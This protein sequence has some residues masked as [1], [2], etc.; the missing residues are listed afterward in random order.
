[1]GSTTGEPVGGCPDGWTRARTVTITNEPDKPLSNFQTLIKVAWDNDMQVDFS[2]LRFVDGLGAPLPH[3]IEDYTAPIEATVWVKVPAIAA[4]GTTEI[5]M[6]YG[7]PDAASGSDGLSTFI[8]FDDFDGA[9]LDAKKWESTLPVTVGA[10]TLK[11]ANGAVYSKGSPGAFPNLMIET[12]YKHAFG[13]PFL[14]ISGA[15]IPTVPRIMV[16]VGYLVYAFVNNDPIKL[17]EGTFPA[18]CCSSPSGDIF[19]AAVDEANIYVFANRTQTAGGKATWKAPI[20]VGLGDPGMKNADNIDKYDA[21]V[22]WFLVRK[23]TSIEPKTKIGPE[24][25]L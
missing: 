13:N 12:K 22:Y 19:G 16:S 1:M 3:W 25:M 18:P 2:D 20:F 21:T 8:F 10:G 23:F 17:L 24:M 15:Q 9:V 7:N 6:C 4:A 5:T 14:T 11:I